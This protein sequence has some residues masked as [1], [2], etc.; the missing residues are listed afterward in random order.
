MLGEFQRPRCGICRHDPAENFLF[1]A[2]LLLPTLSHDQDVVD[3]GDR[4]RAMRD[5]HRD[6]AACTQ[7]ENCAG[8]SLVTFGIKIRIRLVE[9]DQEWIAVERA[10]KRNALRLPGRKRA[11]VIADHCVIALGQVDDEL[12]NAS[13]LGGGD[14][15]V[16]IGRILEATDILRHRS[17]EQFDVLRHIT[18]MAAE[19][20][21]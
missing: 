1:R 18:D 5:D 11:A 20:F 9:H 17:V 6:C 19:R 10:S 15:G 12:M 14:D 13:R 7:P 21:R 2:E 3:A 8:Q 16:G 4:T